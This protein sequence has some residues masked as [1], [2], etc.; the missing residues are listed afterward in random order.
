MSSMR[1]RFAAIA[2]LIATSN[3]AVGDVVCRYTTTSASSVNYYTCTEISAYYSITLDKFLLL[4]P[5]L[6]KSCDTIK[7]NTEYCVAGCKLS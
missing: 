2:G 6:D 4:N 5:S 7:P 3:A 1:M